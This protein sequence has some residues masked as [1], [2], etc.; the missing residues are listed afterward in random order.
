MR[1]TTEDE[2]RQFKAALGEARP[3]KLAAA[4]RVEKSNAR[5]PGGLDG[6]TATRLRK[7]RHEP[8][9]R[10]DLHGHTEAAAHRALLSFLRGAAKNGARLA[11]VVTGK[12]EARDA[13]APYDM[14]LD[15][16]PRGV[17]NAAVP[18]WLNEPA[19]AALIAGTRIAHIRHGGAGALYVYLRKTR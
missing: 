7:G 19:F 1:R 5:R 16:K 13:H 17:L 11:L 4:A 2:H 6:N 10:I 14:G 12:G 18:R 8:D 3:L 15:R 9:V